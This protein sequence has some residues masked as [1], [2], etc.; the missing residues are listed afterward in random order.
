MSENVEE[1]PEADLASML[2]VN[3]EEFQWVPVDEWK[4]KVK[5]KSI[6]KKD[7][8]LL[9]KK[10]T[11]NGVLDTSRMEQLLFVYGIESPK[12][13]SEHVDRL[14]EKRSSALDKVMNAI[15]ELSG[16]VGKKSDPEEAAADFQE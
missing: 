12:I 1:Y 13:T 15:L 7:Q 4:M 14:F 5:V 8:V 6:S 16:M 2:A 10:S 9:R 3:D 11:V